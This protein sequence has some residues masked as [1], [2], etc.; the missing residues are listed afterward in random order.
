M[1]RVIQ[2]RCIKMLRQM[3]GWET[4]F[5]LEMRSLTGKEY[6]H[7]SVSIAISPLDFAPDD[8]FQKFENLLMSFVEKASKRE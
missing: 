4:H 3:H 7:S 8:E 1:E 5:S 6:L 2:T